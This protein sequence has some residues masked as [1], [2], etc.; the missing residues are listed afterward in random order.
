MHKITNLWKFELNRPSKLRDNNERKKHPCHTKLCAFRC[1]I[2]RPQILVWG[3]E[4]KLVENYIFLENYTALEGAVSH[5][6]LYY[7][8]LPITR[9]QVRFYAYNYFE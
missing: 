6:V 8:Q 5:N 3:L 2:G 7:Q 9:Y 4:I 1:L